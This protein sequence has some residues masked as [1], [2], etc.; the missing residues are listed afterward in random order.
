[1]CGVQGADCACV[2]GY[3][4]FSPVLI[5]VFSGGAYDSLDLWPH[6]TLCYASV[7]SAFFSRAK[8]ASTLG[9]LAFFIAL[10]PYFAVSSDDTDAGSRRAACL[11]TPTCLA[12]GT[13]SFS[14]YEDSGE[15]LL[16]CVALHC[17]SP[18]PDFFLSLVQ[19]KK[20]EPPCVSCSVKHTLSLRLDPTTFQSCRLK[21]LL[22]SPC[23]LPCL[24]FP[25][26]IP[27]TSAINNALL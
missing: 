7:S 21:R 10:F 23:V 9:T 3:Q 14:E 8:T 5:F 12:L 11:L 18:R 2:F 25:P 22:K 19:P 26:Y 20:R 6:P 1:M 24:S 27:D 16:R 15:V 4:S 17:T 13:L